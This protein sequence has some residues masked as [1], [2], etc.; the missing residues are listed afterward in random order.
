MRG[1]YSVALPTHYWPEKFPNFSGII[2][3]GSVFFVATLNCVKELFAV[4]YFSHSTQ[5]LIIMINNVINNFRAHVLNHST[6]ADNLGKHELALKIVTIKQAKNA[7]KDDK[8]IKC[9]NK[10]SLVNFN[11]LVKKNTDRS[12]KYHENIE[13]YQSKITDHHAKALAG[14]IDIFKNTPDAITQEGV[15]RLSKM[16]ND[17][18]EITTNDMI[19][20]HDKIKKFAADDP[21]LVPC[22]IKS[23]LGPSF[24][25]KDFKYIE[26]LVQKCAEDSKYT[27]KLSDMPEPLKVVVQ[28]CKEVSKESDKNRMSPT[29]L[30][31]VFAP[32]LM[33]DTTVTSKDLAVVGEICAK[34]NKAFKQMIEN[35]V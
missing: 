23:Q 14:L 35:A 7:A 2:S 1:S 32:C 33:S 30:A 20:G 12:I 5:G 8:L 26:D 3:C 11:K 25:P 10:Y 4:S 24:M 13:K 31:V 16:R 27:P 22:L 15:F 21:N 29:A 6:A 34:Y 28:L 18:V 17:K 19:N 9:Y